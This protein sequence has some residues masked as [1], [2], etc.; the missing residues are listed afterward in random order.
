[1]P[2]LCTWSPEDGTLGA[3]A[4]LALAAAAGTALVV[5]LDPEGPRYPGDA[6]L[7]DLV[8]EGPRRRD[9]EATRRGVAV[10]RNG[11]IAPADA[12]E[13][14]TA[15]EAA[16]PAVV[17]RLPAHPVPQRRGVVPVRPLLPGGVQARWSRPAVH[18]QIGWRL[19]ALGP[20][21]VM[22]TPRRGTVRRLLEGEMPVTDRWL[23]AWSRVWELPWP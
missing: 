10:L 23:R 5:D 22:P 11:G 17:Y 15:L 16:W 8:T 6:S 20:G 9:L 18:Q 4:P 12:A 1:M 2:T 7:H 19:P 13:V 3:V 21:P 14:L